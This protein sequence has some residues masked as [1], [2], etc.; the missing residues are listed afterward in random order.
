M[1]DL[2]GAPWSE[3]E[4]EREIQ[5]R[6]AETL[7]LKVAVSTQFYFVKTL[8]DFGFVPIQNENKF[9]NLEICHETQSFGQIYLLGGKKAQNLI[10]KIP[11][12]S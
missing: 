11:N 7:G 5:K 12:F 8:K 2:D 4:T 10:S 6:K 9:Q 3:T 1:F